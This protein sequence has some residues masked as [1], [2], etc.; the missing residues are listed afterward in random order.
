MSSKT[1]NYQPEQRRKDELTCLNK[2]GFQNEL[3]ELRNDKLTCNKRQ[4][5]SSYY[6]EYS[7]YITLHRE[8]E[9]KSLTWSI[10]HHENY[11]LWNRKFTGMSD[12]KLSKRVPDF[13]KMMRYK[14]Q[15]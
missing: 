1:K 15:S 8:I 5:K 13:A 12:L 2:K 4:E 10:E 7:E 3:N 6:I 14:S 9:R 11:F